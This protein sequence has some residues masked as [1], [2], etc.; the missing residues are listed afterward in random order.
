MPACLR[1]QL[2]NWGTVLIKTLFLS[3]FL[4]FGSTGFNICFAA[5]EVCL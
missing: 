1:A 4:G 3:Q 5:H 2:G